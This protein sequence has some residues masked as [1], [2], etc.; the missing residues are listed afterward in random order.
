M[1][2]PVAIGTGKPD[3]PED[4]HRHKRLGQTDQTDSV[5]HP[6]RQE[7]FGRAH[8]SPESGRRPVVP[9]R[10]SA[11]DSP[12]RPERSE[13]D[14]ATARHQSRGSPMRRIEGQCCPLRRWSCGSRLGAGRTRQPVRER[15]LPR[16]RQAIS[17]DE[18]LTAR[19][20]VT[21]DFAHT[22]KGASPRPYTWRGSLGLTVGVDRGGT[23][24]RPANRPRIS[25]TEAIFSEGQEDLEPNV[26]RVFRGVIILQR[27]T[28]SRNTGLQFLAA[29]TLAVECPPFRRRLID[30][31][32]HHGL[33][34]VL[35]DNV[36]QPL[37]QRG[38]PVKMSAPCGRYS[39]SRSW[40]PGGS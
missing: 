4:H 14:Q 5:R 9:S 40:V 18:I 26:V 8:P 38:A 22:A 34:P 24:L 15:P 33:G 3:S 30:G 21:K 19:R 35:I 31:L 7:T 23:S 6:R 17:R 20:S 13:V 12:C 10:S 28:Q 27:R 32:L 1:D 36:E 16:H 11:R 39:A 37:N 29:P 25:G 2:C